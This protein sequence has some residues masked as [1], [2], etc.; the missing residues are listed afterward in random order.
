M[1]KLNVATFGKKDAIGFLP[2]DLI[3]NAPKFTGRKER[4]EESI[5]AMVTSLLTEGQIQDIVYRI[6]FDRKPILIAG[7]TRA[8]A[9]DRI[10]KQGL[11]DAA[12]NMYSETNPFV[13]TGRCK[14]VNELD[15]LFATFR[16]NDGDTRTPLTMSD[17]VAFVNVLNTN[18]NLTAQ[19]ISE[20][21]RKN[22]AWVTNRLKVVSLDAATMEKLNS[23]E[24]KLDTA[25]TLTEIDPEKREAVVAAA[26][27][28]DGKL[29]AAGVA[30]AARQT[31]AQTGKT[32]KRT[33]KQVK[34]WTKAK[35]NE[36]PVGPVKD[37]LF[38]LLD[39]RQGTNS[40]E[41]LNAAYEALFVKAASA[42]N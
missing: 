33:E 37:F 24:I 29:T 13:L 3:A 40:T 20:K 25:V 23:G 11:T 38:A 12:G 26:V 6:G 21:L 36:A 2:A 5:A 32:L 42:S 1:I 10:N 4:T 41:D 31:G 8:L 30:E 34:D 18:F 9:G 27:A 28:A 16:E 14:N 19:E 15:A 17:E 35:A 22:L 39:Y 7:M